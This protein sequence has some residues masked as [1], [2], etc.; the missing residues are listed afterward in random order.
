MK[1][2]VKSEFIDQWFGSATTEEIEA[3]QEKGFTAEDI[4]RLAMDW[5]VSEE[6]LMEQV[7]EA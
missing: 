6:D 2:I 7:E 5:G 3:A 1:Y 4:N